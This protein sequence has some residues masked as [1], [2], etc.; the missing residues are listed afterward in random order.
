M[1]T[2]TLAKLNELRRLEPRCIHEWQVRQ[3]SG[4]ATV[5]RSCCARSLHDRRA[6]NLLVTLVALQP[7]PQIRNAHRWR[8]TIRVSSEP[9]KHPIESRICLAGNTRVYTGCYKCCKV[10]EPALIHRNGP[11]SMRLWI[12]FGKSL[13]RN[14]ES[15]GHRSYEKLFTKH[16]LFNELDDRSALAFHCRTFS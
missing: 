5:K 3:R 15:P 4:L 9:L 6:R 11:L 10:F 7:A 8:S 12:D 1:T 14:D 16:F 13:H 2:R